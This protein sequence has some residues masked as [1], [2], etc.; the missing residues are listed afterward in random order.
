V[1][2]DSGSVPSQGRR[3]EP[4]AAERDE[5]LAEVLT[6]GEIPGICDRPRLDLG[7]PV[8]EPRSCF[9]LGSEESRPPPPMTRR[10]DEGIR[11]LMST[12]PL[13]DRPG[14]LRTPCVGHLFLPSTIASSALPSYS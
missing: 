3:L 8:F 4:A 7:Q 6:K 14:P 11:G 2:G 5:P 9:G 13:S 12:L 10:I 1:T